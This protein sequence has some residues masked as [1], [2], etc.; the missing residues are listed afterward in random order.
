MLLIFLGFCLNCYECPLSKMPTK[1]YDANIC[2]NVNNGLNL[3]GDIKICNEDQYCFEE[4]TIE[5]KSTGE[6][7]TILIE[8][9][10]VSVKPDSHK[11]NTCQSEKTDSFTESKKCFCDTKLCNASVNPKD[12]DAEGGGFGAG[13][14]ALIVIGVIAII[15]IGIFLIYIYK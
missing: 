13:I 7:K 3:L 10:C 1:T 2:Y 11:I 4:S 14:I 9:Y 8:R 5:T 6:Q 12:G 15:A